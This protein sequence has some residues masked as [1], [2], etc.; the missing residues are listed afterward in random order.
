MGSP[1]QRE[2][3][4]CCLSVRIT[5]WAH[6]LGAECYSSLGL[7]TE[8]LQDRYALPE[9]QFPQSVLARHETAVHA[10]NREF[11]RSLPHHRST[12]V[13]RVILPQCQAMVEAVGHR[14]AHDAAVNAGV[15]P[16]LVALYVA[17]VVKLDP[18]WYSENAALGR[19]VQATMEDAAVLELIPR[20][21]TL[22]EDM[23]VRRY[24]SAPIVSDVQWDGFVEG[25]ELHQ[26]AE[27]GSVPI[28]SVS[29]Q[30]LHLSCR[31]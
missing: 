16:A 21:S 7:A 17:S 27:A 5:H 4:W 22:I 15:D 24:I 23:G 9:S 31:L 8:L 14:M 6:L 10:E 18:A 19:H 30:A 3:S 11:L 13:D 25:L 12:A 26:A 2:I 1:L 29:A 20:L 28:V